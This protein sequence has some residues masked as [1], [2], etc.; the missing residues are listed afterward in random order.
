MTVRDA[1]ASW[2]SVVRL[3]SPAGQLDSTVHGALRLYDI[4]NLVQLIGPDK[5]HIE[6]N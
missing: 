6:N 2:A 1:P 3:K 5:V 4:P